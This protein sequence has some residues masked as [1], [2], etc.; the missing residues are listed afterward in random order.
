MLS[1]NSFAS[2]LMIFTMLTLPAMAQNIAP[3]GANPPAQ[4][5][6]Q[7]GAPPSPASK[8]KI[9]A[10]MQPPSNI[11][12]APQSTLSESKFLSA[13]YAEIARRTPQDNAL[14]EGEVTTSFHINANG[15]VD[16]VTIEKSTSP[17]FSEAVKKILAS[18]EAPPPPG[19]SMDIGQT[20]K[21]HQSAP[22]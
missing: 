1:K 3:S 20:F 7:N 17:L 10:P 13:L 15:R 22:E 6:P 8:A 16:K 18:V 21:F 11:T 12:P 14:G 19:G 4:S 5:S 9:D 2:V